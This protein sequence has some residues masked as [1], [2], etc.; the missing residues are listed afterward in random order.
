MEDLKDVL[1]ENLEF[2]LEQ[3]KIIAARLSL[4]PKGRI[5]KKEVNGGPYYYLR[6]R[7]GKKVVDDYIGKEV[8]EHLPENLEERKKLES[9]LKKVREAIKLLH[10]KND[11]EPDLIEPSGKSCPSLPKG[12]CG[13]RESRSS[14]VGVS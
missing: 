8:P 10:A 12:G 7:K 13:N 9:E 11:P 2:Y 5:K 14:G 6:Y 4:L 1:K 3:E